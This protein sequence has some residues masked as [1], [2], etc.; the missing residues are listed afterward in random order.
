MKETLGNKI[1]AMQKRMQTNAASARKKAFDAA[2]QKRDA[3]PT[4]PRGAGG[5]AGAAKPAAND[6][7]KP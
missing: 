4:T 3:A 2:L 1:D 6:P 7:A 5:R